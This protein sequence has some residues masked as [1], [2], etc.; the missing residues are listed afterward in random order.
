MLFWIVNEDN[1]LNQRNQ[2]PFDV[3]YVNLDRN[4]D[5]EQHME[6]LLDFVG[7]KNHRRFRAVDGKELYTDRSYLKNSFHQSVDI[8]FNFEM[9]KETINATG[10]A[11]TG[12]WLSYLFILKELAAEGT[13]QPLL[14]LEDDVDLEV[15]FKDQLIASMRMAPD[16]WD[17]LLCGNYF[18]IPRVPLPTD[19]TPL[20]LPVKYFSPFHC[21][22]VRNSTSAAR[23]A[24]RADLAVFKEPIDLFVAHLI[25]S[26]NL[27]AYALSTPIAI[28][29]RDLFITTNPESTPIERKALLNSSINLMRRLN[30]F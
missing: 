12:I 16:D 15:D 5:R 21:F 23:I 26:I 27:I 18:L 19:W 22:I 1:Y 9:H 24:N 20:W 10:A 25:P 8:K 13:N 30:K 29:R 2:Y 3:T 6:K 4:K 17:L 11:T 7:L 28:Q 14:V